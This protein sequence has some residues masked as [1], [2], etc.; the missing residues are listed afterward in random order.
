[1]SD[2]TIAATNVD[3]LAPVVWNN[4]QRAGYPVLLLGT[5]ACLLGAEEFKMAPKQSF[6]YRC[7]SLHEQVET[8][9]R[10]ERLLADNCSACC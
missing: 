4:G 1:M 9:L 5:Q 3:N 8:S 7:I 6:F 2:S 10:N